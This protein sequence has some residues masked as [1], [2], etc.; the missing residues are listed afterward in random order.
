MDLEEARSILIILLFLTSVIAFVTELS[1]LNFIFLALLVSLLLISLRINK[2]KED[3]KLKSPSPTGKVTHLN[4]SGA[5]KTITAIKIILVLI[6]FVVVL[7]IIYR[8]LNPSQSNRYTNNVHHFSLIYPNNWEKAEGYKGT[9]VTFAMLG[10]DRI[11]LATCIVKAYWVPPNQRDLR[12]FSEVL[13]NETTKQFLNYT[14]MSEEYKMVNGEEAYDYSMKWISGRDLL[15]SQNRIFIKNENA[16]M[17][18]CSSNQ[19]VFNKYK[20]D[21]GTIIESFKFIE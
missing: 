5:S 2:I 8:D 19:T 11:P 6:S 4:S 21:F 12:I 18:G 3:E 15:V 13:K 1:L 16:Y 7:L 10:N 17:V 14:L 9:L 20:S